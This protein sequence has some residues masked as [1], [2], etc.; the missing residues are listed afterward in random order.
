MGIYRAL[1]QLGIMDQLD[2][3]SSV[4]G[5]TWASAVY[6]F[7]TEFEGQKIDVAELLGKS[8]TP[9]ELTMA[10]LLKDAPPMARGITKGN[11]NSLFWH[12]A[13]TL[14]DNEVWAKVVSDMVLSPFGLDS[15]ESCMAQSAEEVKRIKAE[16]PDLKDMAFLVPNKDRPKIFIMNGALLA[17]RNYDTG[18]DTVV[19][20]QMCPDYTGSPFYPKDESMQDVGE[21]TY[22]PAPLCCIYPCWRAP[23]TLT[24]GGGMIESFAFGGDAP[25]PAA[26][27]GGTV[28]VPKPADTF[29]LPEAV[30]ISSYAPAG[31]FGN[32]RLTAWWLNIRKKY[33][34]ITS[35]VASTPQE[36]RYYSFGDGGNV[37][38]A[39]LL[40]LLQRRA[41]KAIWIASSYRH[42]SSTYDFETETVD[43][44]DPYAAGVLEQL[45]SYFGYGIDK[46]D[47]GWYYSNN[48]VFKKSLLLPI[49]QKLV[50]LKAAGKPA[51]IKETLEVLPNNYWG[52]K[53]GYKV[54]LIL[55]YLEEVKDFQEQLPLETQEELAK[56][57]AGAFENYPI[58]KTTNNNSGDVLGLTTA[59]VNLLA[60]QG[61]YAVRQHAELFKE[62]AADRELST[63]PTILNGPSGLSKSKV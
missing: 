36:E 53:G 28:S 22:Q 63:L 27:H 14:R 25:T 61:E 43:T 20:F 13:G 24:V 57:A 31:G 4:S 32:R 3:I 18:D 50:S 2:G 42:F 8:S 1:Q 47:E 12:R 60:A 6:M 26:Q 40:P 55:I 48:Q 23:I 49:C 9:S 19:S 11:S 16:N 54:S 51:V 59:Q 46:R 62:F 35:D 56:G 45:S 15:F 38:N 33:W 30:G 10:E 58:Y 5:G 34:P 7:A 17:P 39:G 52:I 29:S 44:F 21:I 37:D 41:K